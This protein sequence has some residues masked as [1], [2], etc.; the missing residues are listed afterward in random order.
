MIE[1]IQEVLVNLDKARSAGVIS[2]STR[3]NFKEFLL[4]IRTRIVSGRKLSPGQ[5]KYLNDIEKQCSEEEI[6]LA[7]EWLSDYSDDLRDIAII[8]AEYYES[9]SSGG[10]Y[11][12]NIRNKVL[13]NP[14]GH[15]LSKREFNAMCTN[16]YAVKVINEM[17][18]ENRFKVG[19]IV[20]VRTTNRLDMA[21]HLYE[22]SE[23]RNLSY[24]L[25]KDARYDRKVMA[26]ITG[27][28]TKPMYRATVGGKVY[29]ILPLGHTI[30][31][32]ACEKDL[33]KAKTK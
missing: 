11:F 9:N 22:S 15:T 7:N 30:Q 28:N 6:K 10:N 26:M 33:K 2:N 24:R 17:K 27:V 23:L 12:R 1:R 19:Q 13:E 16:D 4:S 5:N 3:D 20:Q 29:S 18:S 31:L 32:F 14:K 25:H 8:C 21:Q